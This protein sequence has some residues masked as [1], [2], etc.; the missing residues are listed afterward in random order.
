M[1]EK[2]Q[3]QVALPKHDRKAEEA[4]LRFMQTVLDPGSKRYLKEPSLK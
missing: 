4:F 2:R 1:D 3:V